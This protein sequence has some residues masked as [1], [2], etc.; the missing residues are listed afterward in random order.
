M[1]VCYVKCN[2]K[3]QC[4]GAI[5]VYIIVKLT[6]NMYKPLKKVVKL[7]L[8]QVNRCGITSTPRKQSPCKRLPRIHL[9][10]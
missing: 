5:Y 3:I 4:K 2:R 1:S 6:N 9:Q 10:Q 7:F 8:L